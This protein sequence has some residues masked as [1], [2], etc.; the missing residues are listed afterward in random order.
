MTDHNYKTQARDKYVG[1]TEVFG[2]SNMKIYL[3]KLRIIYICLL[4]VLRNECLVFVRDV[5]KRYTNKLK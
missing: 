2:A 5:L 1:G 3:Q 4:N